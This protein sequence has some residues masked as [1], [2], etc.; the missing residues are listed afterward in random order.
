MKNIK[1]FFCSLIATCMLISCADLET[2]NLNNADIDKALGNPN[3]WEAIIQG[4]FNPLWHATQLWRSGAAFTMGTVADAVTSS[5]GNFGMRDMSSEPRIRI[6]NSETYTY[7][8]FIE[9]PYYNFF[10]VIG[11]VNDILKKIA[12]DPSVAPQDANGEVITGKLQS[13]GHFLQGAA[14]GNLALM[15]D[16]AQFADETSDPLTAPELPFDDY[17]TLMDKALGKLDQAVSEAQAAPDFTVGYWNGLSLTKEEFIAVIRTMQARFVAY[18]SR[19]PAENDSND[20]GRVMSFARQGIQSD[21]VVTGDGNLWWDAYKYYGSEPIWS[22]ADYRVMQALAS[23]IPG[24]FPED[25]SHP[26]PIHAPED[27]ID[28]RI[29][30]DFTYAET[31]FFRANRGL[32]HFSH[33]HHTRYFDHY[34]GATGP[35]PHIL[36]AEN[37]LLIAEA[38]VRTGGDRAEAAALINATRVDRGGLPALDGSE[39]DADMITAIL[40]ERY[41]ELM[42]TAGGLPFFDR[43][44]VADDDG[45]FAPYSGLQPGTFRQMPIPAKEL[46]VLEEE[47]Y[48]FGG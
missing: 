29:D 44:R 12:E 47:I 36:K 3:E 38:L 17:N 32:Y 40:H 25:G 30:T 23:N 11:T 28:Q 7:A 24:R 22:R 19:T 45:S 27:V 2:V 46:N 37:D 4:Q 26:F 41:V 39:S 35:M 16:K 10:S 8:Y 33:Y 14:F 20:W 34:P 21:F 31:I 5:W 15:Y 48:T 6:N 18:K 1:L 43:R 9:Y 13:V 42:L